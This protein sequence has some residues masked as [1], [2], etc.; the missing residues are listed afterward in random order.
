MRDGELA[1]ADAHRRI[2]DGQPVLVPHRTRRRRLDWVVVVRSHP[3][4]GVDAHLGFRERAID[5]AA[6]VP[7]GNQPAEDH[8]GLVR[9]VPPFLDGGHG[10][11]ALVV[12]GHQ[13]RSVLRSLVAVGNDQSDRLAGV[14]DDVVL[15][16]KEALARCRA[17]RERWDEL[18]LGGHLG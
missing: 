13:R 1:G 3:I 15:H 8:L 10:G 9:F 6:L 7:C 14:V 17:T 16:R 5:I 18:R 2:V 11:G 12:D 4:F